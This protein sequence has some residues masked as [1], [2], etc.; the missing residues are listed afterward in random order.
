MTAVLG[1]DAAWTT[2]NPSGVAIAKKQAD[3]WHLLALYPSYQEFL[4]QP[5]L[6]NQLPSVSALVAKAKAVAG[7]QI[8]L[9]S[10]DIPLSRQPILGRRVSDDAVSKEYGGRNAST[11]SPSAE[12]PGKI[13]DRLREEFQSCGYPLVTLGIDRPGLIEVYPHP[14]LIELTSAPERLKYKE[15]KIRKYWKD[16]PPFERRRKLLKVWEH[17]IDHLDAKISSVRNLL[18]EV[19]ASSTKKELKAFEDMLDAI[20]CAWVAIEALEG[21]ATPFGDEDSA[22]WIPSRG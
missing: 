9:I 13:S 14:A 16:S 8:Q 5:K 20:V 22:I 3:E 17:I 6:G 21:R 7:T 12:R 10:V 4:E 1:I 18:P 2:K 11:H 15:G 19:S